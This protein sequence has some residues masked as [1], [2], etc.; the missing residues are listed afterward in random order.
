MLRI[1]SIFLNIA[2]VPLSSG[3]GRLVDTRSL[4]DPQPIKQ[5][6]VTSPVA[7]NAHRQVQVHVA[8]KLTLDLLARGRADGL[9]HAPS[10][11]DDDALLGLGLDPDQSP[12]TRKSLARAF[13]LFHDRLDRVRQL[14]KSAPN[15]RLA[16]QLGQQ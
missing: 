11:A 16:N 14:L 8:A 3:P 4:C 2:R 13:D 10:S 7:A 1:L 12:D 15:R 5:P 6:L 9:D